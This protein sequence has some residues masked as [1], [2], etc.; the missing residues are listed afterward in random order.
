MGLVGPEAVWTMVVRL[1]ELW[2]LPEVRAD[3]ILLVKQC[4]KTL[5]LDRSVVRRE[6]LWEITTTPLSPLAAQL[7]PFPSLPGLRVGHDV[8]TVKT[9]L[10]LPEALEE[11]RTRCP[12]CVLDFRL[13]LWTLQSRLCGPGLPSAWSVHFPPPVRCPSTEILGRMTSNT[14]RSDRINSHGSKSQSTNIHS[15]GA[16]MLIS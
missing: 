6:V 4:V 1:L 11:P 15:P 8:S 2:S 7:P 14:P 3:T 13:W 12:E 5:C 10:A 16:H 9:P